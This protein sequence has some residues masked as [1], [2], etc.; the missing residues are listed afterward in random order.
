MEEKKDRSLNPETMRAA[1]EIID[2]HTLKNPILGRDLTAAVNKKGY[3]ISQRRLRTGIKAMRRSRH[4]IGAISGRGGG[5]FRVQNVEEYRRFRQREFLKK[6]SDMAI[7]MRKMDRS[8]EEYFGP[9][10]H[11][12]SKVQMAVEVLINYGSETQPI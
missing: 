8:A 10:L 11:L 1:L 9:Q 2:L 5:Y 7:T 3:T 6:I 12:P 4:M